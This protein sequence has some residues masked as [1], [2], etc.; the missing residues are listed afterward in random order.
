MID[1]SNPQEVAELEQ[2]SQEWHDFRK[3]HRMASES[4]AILGVSPYQKASDIRRVKNGGGGGFVNA[5]MR[6]GTEQEPFARKAYNEKYD[7]MRPAVFVNGMYGASLDGINLEQDGLWECKTPK[8]GFASERAKLC[9]RN[10]L[11]DYDYAQVQHQLMVTQ[12]K[13]CDFCVW[14]WNEVDFIMTR[15]FPDLA[16]WERIHAD[17]ELFWKDLGSRT[18]EKWQSATHKYSI[19]KFALELAQKD[20]DSAKQELLEQLVGDVNEGFGVRV[21]RIT[22]SGSTDWKKVQERYLNDMDLTEFKKPDTYQIRIN[23]IKE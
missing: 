10:E 22:I 17:W 21:Q 11:T 4:P 23:E 9:L 19:K 18:D 13:W 6:K 2:G 3:Q 12:A 5:A 8:D 14:D 16:M 15:V 20:F 1:L 7:P